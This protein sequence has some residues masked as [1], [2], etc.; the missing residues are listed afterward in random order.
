[1]APAMR[2]PPCS[3]EYD[4]RSV[5]PPPSETRSGERVMIMLSPVEIDVH[6]VLDSNFVGIGIYHC[7]PD[8]RLAGKMAPS[9]GVVHEYRMGHLLDFYFP[10]FR[11]GAR[12]VQP[13]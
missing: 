7:F 8:C 3:R 13:V 5:P 2:K 10:V 4:G 12:A 1:M 9:Y 11:R 6:I